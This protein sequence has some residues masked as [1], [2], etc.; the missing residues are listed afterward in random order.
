MLVAQ[1]ISYISKKFEILKDINLEIRKGKIISIIGPNGAGKSTLLAVLSGEL[2]TQGNVFFKGKPYS[3][4]D[5]QTLAQHKA[6]FSQQ[7]STDIPLL[8]KDVIV[9]GRYPYFEN[10]PSA[11]DLQAINQAMYKT[12]VIHLQER[13]YNTLSGGEKQRVHL[14]RVMAQ[15]D[16]QIENKLLFFDEPLNN[17]DIYHQYNILENIKKIAIEGNTVVVV[18]HDLNLAARF[19]DAIILMKN[20]KIINYDTPEKVFTEP[21]ISATYDF[22]CKIITNPID[23]GIMVVFG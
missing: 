3:E 17:L 6:K 14:A 15:A 13:E 5:L 22:P 12:D 11:V 21:I 23:R 20:G 7:Y 1:H 16:N 9:M 19:S 8:V 2:Q 4:W 10:N 18:M